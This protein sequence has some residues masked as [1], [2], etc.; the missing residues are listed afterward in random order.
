MKPAGPHFVRT[1]RSTLSIPSCGCH[2][3]V[4]MVVHPSHDGKI[5][6]NPRDVMHARSRSAKE[7]RPPRP[8][9]GRTSTQ[10]SHGSLSV[11][12]PGVVGR[13]VSGGASVCIPT[14]VSGAMIAFDDG[15][16]LVLM[17]HRHARNLGHLTSCQTSLNNLI[18]LK[19]CSPCCCKDASRRRITAACPNQY[20]TA[21]N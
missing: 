16:A 20:G 4:A 8:C 2:K 5:Q 6:L 10:R 13:G 17:T 18:F 11:V 21:R 9:L 15:A 19:I 3:Y 7:D 1:T 14:C 12:S